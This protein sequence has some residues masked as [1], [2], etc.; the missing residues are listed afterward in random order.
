VFVVTSYADDGRPVAVPELAAERDRHRVPH[1][2]PCP[3]RPAGGRR[4]HAGA[5]GLAQP[6]RGR[7]PPAVP[8]PRLPV[9]R[10]RRA[11]AEGRAARRL[12]SSLRPHVGGGRTQ[13]VCLPA[14]GSLRLRRDLPCEGEDVGA[15][16]S[17]VQGPLAAAHPA[18]ARPAS[19]RR[20]RTGRGTRL[21]FTKL[22][23]AE[24][25]SSL[26]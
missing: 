12:P 22:R 9:R 6:V 13:P 14:S 26:R 7:A 8:L 19:R 20:A 21:T 24:P 10:A 25:A 1:A 17:P 15:G 5:A 16:R 2:D 18:G 23:E 11:C 4:A 3:P